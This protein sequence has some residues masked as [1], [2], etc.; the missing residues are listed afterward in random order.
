MQENHIGGD[1][2]NWYVCEFIYCVNLH[3]QEND[4]IFID[5]VKY[6]YSWEGVGSV[7]IRS[8]ETYVHSIHVCCDFVCVCDTV[9]VQTTF[10]FVSVLH[11]SV[12]NI[13]NAV[14]RYHVGI[15]HAK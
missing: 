8:C 4:Y 12:L 7:L 15:E 5:G 10:Y 13:R 2:C 9:R 11:V 14:Y 6:M 1:N 3:A